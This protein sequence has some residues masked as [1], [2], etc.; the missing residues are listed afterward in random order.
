MAGANSHPH[1]APRL[2]NKKEAAAYLGYKSTWILENLDIKPITI[3][4]VGGS[5]RDL[6]DRK[7]ID[8]YLDQL[9]GIQDIGEIAIIE[10][11]D[12]DEAF[13]RWEEG[14]KVHAA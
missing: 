12:P 8:L 7:A 2:L 1:V 5:S 14:R 4:T 3:A 11:I 13:R 6:Y 10:E 9:S